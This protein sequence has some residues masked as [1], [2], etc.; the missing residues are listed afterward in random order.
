ML[1]IVSLNSSLSDAIVDRVGALGRKVIRLNAEDRLVCV[2]AKIR[3]F[4]SQVDSFE[5]L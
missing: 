1:L 5:C 2:P 3:F 4:R